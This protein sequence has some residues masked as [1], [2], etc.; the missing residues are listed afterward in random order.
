MTLISVLQ[1][2]G[3]YLTWRKATRLRL[4]K[5]RLHNRLCPAKATAVLI[6]MVPLAGLCDVC[7]CVGALVVV[8]DVVRDVVRGVVR[9]V[10]SDSS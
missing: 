10:A 9:G 6:K 7:V 1:L 5:R 8:R 3:T 4:G 2:A